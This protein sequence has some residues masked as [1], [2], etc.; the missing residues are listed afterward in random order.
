MVGPD[1]VNFNFYVEEAFNTL[2]PDREDAIVKMVD[3]HA[4]TGNEAEYYYV[5]ADS[6]SF[7][8]ILAQLRALGAPIPKEVVQVVDVLNKL[9]FI[10]Y[11]LNLSVKIEGGF[12]IGTRPALALNLQALKDDFGSDHPSYGWDEM[13][14]IDKSNCPSSTI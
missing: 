12:V 7:P 14:V 11:T 1:G 4:T 6:F 5:C 10:F 13:K 8:A 2:F 3:F 9:N